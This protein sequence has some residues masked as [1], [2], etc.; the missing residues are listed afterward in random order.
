M[1]V[2]REDFLREALRLGWFTV[3]WNVIEGLVAINAALMAGSGALLGFGFD[4]GVESLSAA[5]LIWRLQVE[6]RDP[7]RAER[8][9]RQAVRAIG[10]TFF[11]LGAVVAFDAVR[12]LV[13]RIE[14]E[15]SIVGIVLTALSLVVMPLLAVRKRRVGVAMGSKAVEAD[16]TQT[17]ACAYLSA[18]VLAGLVLNAIAGWWWADPVAA[19]V[20]V[21]ILM[22][23][24]WEAVHAERVDDCC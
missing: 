3:G 14:P 8:V 2:Q 4:S 13:D 22:R 21:A 9:E 15:N 18:V 24:G 23:E 6:R 19:L 16:S 11:V 20:V 10:V 7:Q 1:A 17:S 12:S 5:V